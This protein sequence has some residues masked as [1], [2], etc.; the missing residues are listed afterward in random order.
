MRVVSVISFT[1]PLNLLTKR[2]DDDKAQQDKVTRKRVA[3][4]IS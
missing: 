4:F 3:F 2:L 1:K